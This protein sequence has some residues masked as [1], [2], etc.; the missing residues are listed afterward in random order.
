MRIRQD[1]ERQQARSGLGLTRLL[2]LFGISRSTY[3]DWRK[4]SGAEVSRRFNPLTV[5]AEEEAAVVRFRHS[6]LGLSVP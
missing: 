1:I 6:H 3:Y 2:L 4:D 5:L